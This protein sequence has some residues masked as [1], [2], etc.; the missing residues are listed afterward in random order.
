MQSNG[1]SE[2]CSIE[3]DGKCLKTYLN[4]ST[5]DLSFKVR[6]QGQ[7]LYSGESFTEARSIYEDRCH[8]D[9]PGTESC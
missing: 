4:P 3:K 1:T 5:G 8:A 6:D 9:P 2:I 7:V